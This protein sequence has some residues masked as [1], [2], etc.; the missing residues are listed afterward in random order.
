MLLKLNERERRER[1]GGGRIVCV[2]RLFQAKG[3]RKTVVMGV[4]AKDL[5]RPTR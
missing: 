4:V 2:K 5:S 3:R 1:E